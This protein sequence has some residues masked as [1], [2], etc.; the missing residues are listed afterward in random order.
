MTIKS[1]SVIERAPSHT[2]AAAPYGARG[3]LVVG[4][5]LSVVDTSLGFHEFVMREFG[6]GFTPGQRVRVS[7]TD[8]VPLVWMEGNVE[9]YEGQTL[10]LNVDLMS[11]TGGTFSTWDVG[12]TGERGSPGAAG[13]VGPAGPPGTPGGPA[14]P[15]GPEGAQG[16][17]GPPGD[18]GPKG[19]KG[20]P[21]DPGGPPGPEGPA[22]PQGPQGIQG[23]EGPAG[24][25]GVQGDPGPIGPEGP[26]GPIGPEGPQGPEGPEG[27]AGT[28]TDNS[29]TNA[30]LADMP[31]AHF[32]ARVSA[33][34]GDPEDATG[35]QATALLDLFTSAAK[36]LVPPSGGGTTNYLRADGTFAAPPGSGGGAL[37]VVH[38][39]FTAN[40]N[41]VPS[42]GLVCAVFETVAGGAGG[43]LGSCPATNMVMC[44]GA[45]GAGGY[46]RAVKTAAQIGATQP[47]TVG[48]GGAGGVAGTNNGQ[49]GGDTF[50]GASLAAALCGAKGGLGGTGADA[51]GGA[52]LGLGGAG[53]PTTGAVGDF[54]AAG[55]PGTS[56]EW[57]NNLG[58]PV[59]IM[60]TC[61]G[62]SYFGG[63]AAPVGGISSAVPGNPGRNYG[64]GGGGG[65]VNNVAGT[66]NGGAGFAGVV[67]IT[68]YLAATATPPVLANASTFGVR[69][70]AANAA[71]NTITVTFIEAAL[72]D[73]NGAAYLFKNGSFTLNQ[74]V[75]GAGG[76]DAALSNGDIHVYAIWGAAA[77]SGNGILSMTA[78]AAGGPALPTNY[79]HWAYLTTIKRISGSL[80]S[81]YVRGSKVFYTTY[82]QILSGANSGGSWAGITT[83]AYVPALATNVLFSANHIAST[84]ASGGA[85][86]WTLLGFIS[87]GTCYSGRVDIPQGNATADAQMHGILPN[88]AQ[89]LYY[90]YSIIYGAPNFA[91]SGF[92]LW[93]SGYEVPNDS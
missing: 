67:L 58:A 45:G 60:G 63:G 50:V 73:V 40:G 61:G 27:P 85:G 90:N 34:T 24:A 83:S 26:E 91:S 79:T 59:Y 41:Y 12:V 15:Q 9:S 31:T 74:T 38:R 22:G 11:S 20:D 80:S 17:P 36:G 76:Y 46:S 89:T 29:V 25:Q 35:T 6:L 48:A 8:S 66:V 44:G 55:A 70:L 5:S 42:A 93:I 23:P 43:G 14:G 37:N 68:E 81:V 69:G 30:K 39:L 54:V 53:G 51:S 72:R 13:P 10:A 33:G 92:D 21:G 7:A 75:A 86:L 71:T 47:I 82:Q 52:Y 3:P 88:V 77:P 87:G 57:N 78:P 1:I 19:D 28:V 4:T 32:K 16:L 18:P 64:G 62:S 2:A 65:V 49:P 56:G 84:N